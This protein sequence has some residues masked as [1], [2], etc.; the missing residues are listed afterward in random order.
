[1]YR[2]Y[3]HR[4]AACYSASSSQLG[5]RLTVYPSPQFL[6]INGRFYHAFPAS[7]RGLRNQ[8]QHG[9]F[10]PS[11]LPDFIV[12]TGHSAILLPFGPFP[13]STVIGPTSLSRNFFLGQAGLLQFPSCPCYRVAAITPPVWTISLASVRQPLLSSPIFER[14]DHRSSNRLLRGLLSVHSRCNP[15]TRSS[16]LR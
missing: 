10:A 16:T 2:E 8:T 4:P 15:V 7:L 11:A 14:L 3:F 12:T 6:Q 13:V 1:M 9:P 5:F